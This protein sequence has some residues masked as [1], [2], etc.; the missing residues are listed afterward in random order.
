M[1][2]LSPRFFKA[3]KNFLHNAMKQV[4]DLAEDKHT[5]T[6][7]QAGKRIDK[8]ADTTTA[9]RGEEESH[10]LAIPRYLFLDVTCEKGDSVA[11]TGIFDGEFPMYFY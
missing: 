10:D 4:L 6:L 8:L 1:T 3:R 11:L 7:M 5:L 2:F 9:N